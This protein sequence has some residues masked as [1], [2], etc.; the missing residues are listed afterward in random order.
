MADLHVI[1]LILT[2]L[3]RCVESHF[4]G[5]DA[6]LFYTEVNLERDIMELI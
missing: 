2:M 3:W 5:P 4:L 6:Q 1:P